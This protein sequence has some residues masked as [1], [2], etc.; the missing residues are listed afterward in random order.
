MGKTCRLFD[1]MEPFCVAVKYLTVCRLP[2]EDAQRAVEPGA[3]AVAEPFWLSFSSCIIRTH[4]AV[5]A[6]LRCT[7][8]RARHVPGTVIHG[9]SLSP[10]DASRAAEPGAWAVAEPFR[11][12]RFS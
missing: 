9:Y 11:L 2:L 10:E 4:P 8:N 12:P 1:T 5:A 7:S 3:R 6:V